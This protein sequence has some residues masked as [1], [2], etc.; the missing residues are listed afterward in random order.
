M[1]I[2]KNIGKWN[3]KDS[4]VVDDIAYTLYLNH[5]KKKYILSEKT[6][7]SQKEVKNYYERD[8]KYYSE[9]KY[10]L[11]EEKIKKIMSEKNI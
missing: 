10:I 7:L 9:V 6:I 4:T 5:H 11:R 3:L 2:N 8:G 1:E